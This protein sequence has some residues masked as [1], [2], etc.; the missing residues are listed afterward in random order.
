M[1]TDRQL[2]GPRIGLFGIGLAAYWP[3]FA[4]LRERLEGYQSVVRSR[5]QEFGADVID[6]GLVDSVTRAHEA[7]ELFARERVSLVFCYVATYATSSVVL[8]VV[9]RAKCPVVV[10]NLQ[11]VPALDYLRTDTAEWLANCCTCCVPEISCAFARAHIP[12]HVVSGML[13]DDE[14]AWGEIRSWVQAT[15]VTEVLSRTRIGFLGHTYPGM[16]DMYSDFT[17][18]QAELGI[19]IEILEMEDLQLRIAAVSP[20]EK[21]RKREEIFALFEIADPGRDRIAKPVTEEVLDWTITVACGLDRLVRDFELGGLSYYYRGL[22]ENEFE[23]I[24]AAMIVGAS[25]L[26]ARGIPCAGEGDIKTCLAMKIMDLLGCGGSFTEF[27]AMDFNEQF[28]LMGHDGPGHVAIS[29]GRPVLRALGLYHGKRGYGISVEFNV[30]LGPVT[31]LGMTETGD[32]RVKLLAAEGESIPGER[33]QIGNTNSRIRFKLGPAEFVDAWCG[34][35]PTHHV[36]LGVGH[37]A[38]TLSKVAR[39]LGVEYRVVAA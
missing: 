7:G 15:L 29:E 2:T 26:T 37:Q 21:K 12:F 27:Y 35:G 13:G 31:I 39:L 6:A 5:L 34:E 19:H 25:L 10:L 1:V 38:R 11:P 3:Q 8:P 28:V 14:R 23:Q 9:Q 30:R 4:G 18:L 20:E 33:L 22:N 17:R 16:L 36:A 32:G 24:A